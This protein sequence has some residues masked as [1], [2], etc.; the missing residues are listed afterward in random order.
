MALYDRNC[1]A[2]GK[3]VAQ[4]EV[5]IWESGGWPCPRCGQ[6]LRSASISMKL[7]WAITLVISAGTCFYFGLRDSS[8]ILVTLIAAV[9]TSFIVHAVI[10]LV[11]S[12]PL[13]LV[14]TE[15]DTASKTDGNPI[16]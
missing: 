3:V 9:P 13:K 7:T 15:G 1:P 12:G 8:L 11:S 14:P 5:P 4:R 10:G 6:L 16:P 2:C